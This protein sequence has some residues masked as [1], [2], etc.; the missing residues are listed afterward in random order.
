M[1]ISIW[2]E[3][4]KD[5]C[6]HLVFCHLAINGCEVLKTLSVDK[7]QSF[8]NPIKVMMWLLW[9]SRTTF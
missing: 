5:L 2:Q 4:A 7:I 9:T 8:L 3:K 6:G 1:K